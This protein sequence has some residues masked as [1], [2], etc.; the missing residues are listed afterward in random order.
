MK[1][2]EAGLLLFNL[3][4][5]LVFCDYLS[6]HA[7]NWES[8][9]SLSNSLPIKTSWL[10][11]SSPH[12]LSSIEI[13]LPA[14]WKTCLLSLSLNQRIPFALKTSLFNWLSRKYWNFLREKGSLVWK[15]TER[16]S[17][18]LLSSSE[19]PCPCPCPWEW[20]WTD[21]FWLIR[22]VSNRPKLI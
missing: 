1:A 16:K 17:S 9:F 5:N 14:R 3:F 2:F 20:S 22:S 21:S 18:I 15:E 4:L 10:F 8:I 11:L 12:S 6:I 7:F 13:L 19:C